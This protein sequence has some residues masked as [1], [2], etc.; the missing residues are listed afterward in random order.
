MNLEQTNSFQEVGARHCLK[1]HKDFEHK[2]SERPHVMDC[3]FEISNCG[4]LEGK[5][6]EFNSKICN[7]QYEQG[8]SRNCP[9][10][11]EMP[12]PESPEE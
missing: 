5:E 6:C 7:C 4:R 9:M 2:E 3:H 10:F 11:V 12:N 8:H 1:C